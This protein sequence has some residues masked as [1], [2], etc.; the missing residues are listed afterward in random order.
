[1]V[2]GTLQQN[3]IVEGS[4]VILLAN[5]PMGENCGARQ[6]QDVAALRSYA[7]SIKALQQ[8]PKTNKIP[9]QSQ[10]VPTNQLLQQKAADA[11]NLPV[12]TTGGNQAHPP[13]RILQQQPP[14]PTSL[15]QQRQPKVYYSRSECDGKGSGT[16]QLNL[17]KTASNSAQLCAQQQPANRKIIKLRIKVPTGASFDLDVDNSSDVVAFRNEIA[18][19]IKLSK[20]RVYLLHG[21]Q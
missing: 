18:R 12:R 11:R 3:R 15:P 2:T 17:A 10:Q 16:N 8:Q 7:S 1:M 14:P 21:D 6:K 9:T 20:D 5:V 13:I 4:N 19:L